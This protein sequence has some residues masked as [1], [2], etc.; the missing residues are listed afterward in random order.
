MSNEFNPTLTIN[1]LESYNEQIR[2]IADRLVVVRTELLAL[3]K[4]KEDII[5]LF[6]ETHFPDAAEGKITMSAYERMLKHA[7][8]IEDIKIKGVKIRLSGLKEQMQ[9][10]ENENTNFRL[11]LKI[12]SRL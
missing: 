3:E 11:I 8:R 5:A 4:G 1:K 7:T 9:V 2:K 12:E 10:Y 6:H